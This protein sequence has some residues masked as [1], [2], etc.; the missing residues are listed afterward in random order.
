MSVELKIYNNIIEPGTI[1]DP[2]KKLMDYNVNGLDE[3]DRIITLITK[4]NFRVKLPTEYLMISD[5]CKVALNEDKNTNE[6]EVNVTEKIMHYIIQY[7][8]IRKG[9]EIRIG[10]SHLSNMNKK[11]KLEEIKRLNDFGISYKCRSA[12]MEENLLP[13]DGYDYKQEID[14]INQFNHNNASDLLLLAESANY[15]AIH[16]LLA[17]C[18]IKIKSFTIGVKMKYL[19]EHTSTIFNQNK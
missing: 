15:L 7:I 5:L 17:L 9:K 4:D 11:E 6:I 1:V 18:M 19:A 10:Y 16:S 13:C 12:K 8:N 14:F 3:Y 2:V